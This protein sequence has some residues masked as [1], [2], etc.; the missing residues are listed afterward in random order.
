MRPR[1]AQVCARGI[2][3][4]FDDDGYATELAK[5]PLV[6]KPNWAATSLCFVS[7]RPEAYR[8]ARYR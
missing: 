4:R 7:L 1:E 8:M 5:K 2:V 6:P 3:V